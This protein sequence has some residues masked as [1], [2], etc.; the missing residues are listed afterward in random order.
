MASDFYD[1]P[2][3]AMNP[4]WAPDSAWLAYTKQLPS[5][6]R[7]LFVYSLATGK[8]VQVTDGLSDIEFPAF[9]KSGKYLYFTGSTD[10]GLTTGW[11][12]M[13][14]LD[15]PVT[16][17]VYLAVLSKD[18]TS[19]LAPESD[20]EKIKEEIKQAAEDKAKGKDKGKEQA[21][22]FQLRLR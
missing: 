4:A 2:Q 19:P 13:S 5:H 8:A 15:H 21:I 14:S 6:L 9:D 18:T 1:N 7:A 11:L 12:D 16:R 20:E 17:N 10:V 3:R 22:R